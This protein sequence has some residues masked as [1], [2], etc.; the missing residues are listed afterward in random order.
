MILQSK[1]LS[2]ETS[3]FLTQIIF[4]KSFNLIQCFNMKT[5]DFTHS[6]DSDELAHNSYLIWIYIFALYSW[7]FQYHIAF[8][9]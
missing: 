6:V 4:L 9:L 7:N 3:D 8:V 2:T 5:V 1:I